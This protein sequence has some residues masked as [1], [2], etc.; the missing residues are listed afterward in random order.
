MTHPTLF[1]VKNIVEMYEKDILPLEIAGSAG[2]LPRGR[3]RQRRG[4]QGLPGRVRLCARRTTFP[5]CTSA[6]SPAGWKA[7]TCSAE[8]LW[9][10]QF[11][12]I[13][14]TASGI[15]FTGGM[16]IPPA[17]YGQGTS[18]LTEPTTPARSLLRNLFS[19]SPAG[20][21]TKP[22]L[23]PVPGRAAG[24]FP[25]WPSASASRA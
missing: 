1:Q 15:I 6:R 17:V 12:E 13:F 24:I 7:R 20:R 8:N 25:S 10:P 4:G 16:D 22:G 9:T 11:K 18:L 21:R 2:D 14:A 19:L 23:H 3:T 5:G